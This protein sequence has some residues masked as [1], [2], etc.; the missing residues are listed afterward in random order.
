MDKFRQFLKL[1]RQPVSGLTL[2]ASENQIERRDE[3]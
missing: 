3:I 2:D 1:T